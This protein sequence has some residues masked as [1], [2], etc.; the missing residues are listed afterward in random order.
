[1][2]QNAVGWSIPKNKWNRISHLYRQ[3]IIILHYARKVRDAT[4][5]VSMSSLLKAYKVEK[6]S[7]RVEN[8]YK[9]IE[10]TIKAVNIFA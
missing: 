6:I 8:Y 9:Y 3:R 10:V 7:G 1:M 5:G 4:G 2:S